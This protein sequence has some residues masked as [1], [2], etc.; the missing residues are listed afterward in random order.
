[1]QHFKYVFGLFLAVVLMTACKPD[2]NNN[3]NTASSSTSAQTEAQGS[4]A[5]PVLS[6]PDKPKVQLLLRSPY[7]VAE[8]WVNHEDNS[9]NQGNKGRWWALKADG[10]FTTGQWEETYSSGSWVVYNDGPK[11]LLHLDAANDNLDMEFELQAVSS[12]EDYMSWSG[13][14]TYKMSRIAVKAIALMS[15]PTKQQFGVQ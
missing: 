7:W 1:M 14:K 4:Y 3:N 11:D 15:M 6:N 2:A 10:T 8:Y 9:Q 13:T 5:T 12:M